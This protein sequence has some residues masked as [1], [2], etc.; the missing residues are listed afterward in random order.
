MRKIALIV[1]MTFTGGCGSFSQGQQTVQPLACM[2]GL[3]PAGERLQEAVE[4]IQ[5][6]RKK[7]QARVVPKVEDLDA[8]VVIVRAGQKYAICIDQTR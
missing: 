3:L 4:E 6:L 5:V 8:T 2:P 7:I 1:A